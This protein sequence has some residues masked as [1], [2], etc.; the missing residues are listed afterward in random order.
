MQKSFSQKS[1]SVLFII[2]YSYEGSWTLGSLSMRSAAATLWMSVLQHHSLP[3]F[4]R[5]VFSL[6]LINL[7]PSLIS[8]TTRIMQISDNS[9]DVFFSVY[10]Q[11][12]RMNVLSIFTFPG[13][14]GGSIIFNLTSN[15]IRAQTKLRISI[16]QTS[17][18][19]LL[20]FW[21]LSCGSFIMVM[22]IKLV[23]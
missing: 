20:N 16:W 7:I 9:C 21:Q 10:D 13:E 1:F 12:E 6:F 4:P 17:K 19:S 18:W 15:V 23:L 14:M 8:V 2:E 5:A 3:S 11:K 22:F